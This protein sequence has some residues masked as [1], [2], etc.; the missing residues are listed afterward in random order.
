MVRRLGKGVRMGVSSQLDF[1]RDVETVGR[2]P[3]I[4]S[5]LKVICDTTDMGFALVAR[6]T[7]D[8][9]MACQVLDR[10]GRGLRAG[11][12]LPLDTT[13]CEEVRR[14]A[15]AIVID[16]VPTDPLYAGHPTPL[17]YGLQSYISVPIVLADGSFFGTLCA[18]DSKPTRLRNTPVVQMFH[19]FA[20]LIANHIDEQRTLE[21]TRQA[22]RETHELGRLR[23]EFVAVL[24]HDLRNPLAVIEA[25]MRR[26]QRQEQTETSRGILA[27]MQG[28]TRRMAGLLD[29]V[30]DLA[31]TRLG[32]GLSVKLQDLPME[33]VVRQ[34][35]AESRLANP[36]RTIELDLQ[37][38]LVCAYDP[39][40]FGQLLSNLLVNAV[41]HGD[42]HSTIRVEVRRLGHAVEVSVANGG[43]R[44]PPDA[45]VRLFQP[46]YRGCTANKNGL[47]LGLY[48]VSEI[49]KAHRGTLEVMSD[50]TRTL[51]Q[52]RMPAGRHVP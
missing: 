12:E 20:D 32:T 14:C 4:P 18:V 3:V 31:R 41:L 10:E 27:S 5:I 19:L 13:L 2:I 28:T 11:D 47:G 8:R 35:V 1:A 37:E 16:D 15:D 23:E 49:A 26:L 33:P 38:G 44:I 52:F 30:L 45:L 34:V 40:R 51:F 39:V 21:E 24:G 9:W 48:I 42:A 17:I 36:A 7:Q 25:G 43:A 50:D 29:N 22:L 46:F 6:V